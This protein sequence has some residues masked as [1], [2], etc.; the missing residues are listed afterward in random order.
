MRRFFNGADTVDGATNVAVNHA[1][2]AAAGADV[3]VLSGE[4]VVLDGASTADEDADRLLFIWGQVSGSPKVTLVDGFSSAPRFF[5]PTVT[6]TT[7]LT[8]RLTV[9]D[10]QAI[11]SDEVS[12]TVWP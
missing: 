9:G 11:S 6:S 1:P 5:A 3:G 7:V 8:F 12:V 10:G 2:V 4:L